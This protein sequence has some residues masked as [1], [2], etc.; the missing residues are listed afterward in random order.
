MLTLVQS[1][2]NRL[3]PI[4]FIFFTFIGHAQADVSEQALQ[5]LNSA[6]GKCA[7]ETASDI[8]SLINTEVK[9][10]RSAC[11]ELRGCKKEAREEKRDCKDECKAKEG[12]D[13]KSCMQACRETKKD[14]VKSC[15]EAYK[16]PECKSARGKIISRLGKIVVSTIK[17]QECRQ[18]VQELKKLK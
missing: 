16:T 12:K 18:A 17:D 14:A 1:I 4:A 15:R 7:K 3:L 6:A 11:A 5:F 9:A 10:A 2:F 13:K 8:M